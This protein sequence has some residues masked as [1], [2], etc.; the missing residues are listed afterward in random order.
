M[1]QLINPVLFVVKLLVG[2]CHL[3]VIL[4]RSLC[5]RGQ[6]V[7][8]ILVLFHQFQSLQGLEDPAGHTLGAS[9]EV[10]GHDTIL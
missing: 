8:P 7:A 5:P 3:C 1:R 6:F 9:A 10:A 2:S 4:F